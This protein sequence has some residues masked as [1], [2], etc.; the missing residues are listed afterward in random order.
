PPDWSAGTRYEA[1]Q[2]AAE[3]ALAEVWAEVL[4][5]ERIGRH[6]NFFELG[7]HSLLAIRLLERMRQEGLHADVRLLFQHPELAAF[8][9]EMAAR[10]RLSGNQQAVVAAPPNGIP[11]NCTA[12]TPSMLTMV[13]LTP[14]Q[15]SVLEQTVPGGAANI[16]DLYPLVPLQ[17]GILFHHLLQS[18]GDAYVTRCLLSFDSEAALQRFIAD[19][20]QVIDR[21]DILRT[22]ILWE[23]LPA[24]VQLV[25]RHA[26]LTLEWLPPGDNA[27]ARLQAHVDPAHYRIDVR[28]APLLR[29]VAVHDI[30]SQR[31]LLQLPSHNLVLD[32]TTQELLIEEIA[33]IQQDR[34]AELP[35][36]VPFRDFVARA[37]LGVS[38]EEHE[39]FL[40]AMLADVEEPTAPFG[41]LDVQG[42]GLGVEELRLPL[43]AGLAASVR[44]LA[45]Q[46]GVSPAAIFHLAW[47]AV[48]AR[49]SGKDDVVF[50]TVMFGRMQGGA[51]I[52]RALGMFINT[53]PVRARLHGRG[54]AEALGDMHALLTELLHHEHASLTLAQRCSGLA[55]GTP[56]FSA[57]FNYRYS[58]RAEAG[59]QPVL[60]GVQ[61]LGGGERTSY[62]YTLSVDDL[63]LGYGLVLQVTERVGA[64]RMADYMVAALT[65]LATA[66]EHTPALPIDALPLA[67][68]KEAAELLRLGVNSRRHPDRETVLQL[69][70]REVRAH[71]DATALV[72]GDETLS[73]AELNRR[74]NRLA[75]HL[76]AL[77]VRPEM[78]V[79]VAL[80]RSTGMIVGLLAILKAGGAYVPLDPDYPQ[81][82]LGAMIADSGMRL[83]LTQTS[84]AARIPAPAGLRVLLTDALDLS[85]HGDHNPTVVTHG[86]ALAYIIYTSGSTGKPKG[87]GITHATLAEHSQVA[88]GYFGLTRD[89]RMLQFSTINFDGFVEQLFPAL[90]CG[91]A[92]VLRGPTLW[93]SATFRHELLARGITIA[94]L[95]TAYWH[96]L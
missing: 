8:A 32:H 6:D 24:P 16:Q 17:E 65:A 31:W 57:L 48:L 11:D 5:Q 45:Q 20:N 28:R 44:R 71:P 37:R 85:A 88:Q 61:V 15:I 43:E 23:G 9:R 84:A 62:P 87:I 47:A 93:D 1:P 4:G 96:M 83:L 27:Q 79:G 80:E 70:E 86:A 35:V 26:P 19:V 67:P 7:G 59:A 2:G 40:R 51:G 78:P 39:R 81:E 73:Y 41:I 94:D 14:A 69:F 10:Q 89:D 58:P 54:V 34:A 68:P 22:A 3:Q 77:G 42:D 95:P 49:T 46:A 91:A 90:T 38:E 66:L 72:H 75:H 13:S 55:A 64:R 53:L 74:V 29:A 92:V 76:I 12:I 18:A 60:Q 63:G 56:L 36:P 82:R 25:H 21:H 52:E 30:P 50:G 33:M